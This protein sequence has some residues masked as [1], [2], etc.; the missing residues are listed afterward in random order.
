MTHKHFPNSPG[1]LNKTTNIYTYTCKCGCK[2]K[3]SRVAIR[4]M[5]SGEN[6]TYNPDIIHW[7]DSEAPPVTVKAVDPKRKIRRIGDE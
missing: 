7:A 6:A 2:G 1:S 5:C 3:V 4:K